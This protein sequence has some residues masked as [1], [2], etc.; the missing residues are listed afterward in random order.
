MTKW[1]LYERLRPH[2][3][4]AILEGAP[5]AY[6]PWGAL[7]WHSYHNPI[8]VDGL[9]A[10]GLCE[11]MAKE[12]GGVVLPVV[13]AGTETIKPYKGFGH[14][15]DHPRSTIETL[16]REFL[17]QLADEGFRVIVIVAGHYSGAQVEALK[18][19]AEAFMR[20]NP[21]VKVWAFA[22]W[23]PVADLSGNFAG[24]HAAI[25]E[26]SYMMLFEPETVDLAQLPDDRETTLDGDGVMGI[27]PRQSSAQ[28][29]AE[30]LAAF[31][32][33]AVPVIKEMLA[34]VG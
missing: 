3:I 10:H 30:L 13:Y 1:G 11:A 9:K 16:C 26:T 19:T 18:H 33:K 29:G 31:V 27:D 6:I 7:E 28:I 23:E 5:V 25:G 20:K 32:E 2:Q 15:L 21:N 12:T 17:E 22:D 4:E 8:G 34:D 24:N 14:T